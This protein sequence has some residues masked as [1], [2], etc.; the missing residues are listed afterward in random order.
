MKAKEKEPKAQ[1]FLQWVGAMFYPTVDD[2]ID[3]AKTQGIC[4]RI[5]TLPNNLEVGR[6]RIFLAHDE[7]LNGD[8][9]VFGY[10]VPS[11]IE[12]LTHNEKDIPD[13]LQDRVEW[14]S[15]WSGEEYRGCGHREE[16][17]Y[18]SGNPRK[19]QLPG[20]F[21][22]FK[23]PRKLE[24]FDPERGHFRGLLQIDYGSKIVRPLKSQTMV[25]PSKIDRE[26]R[27]VDN[28]ELYDRM[29]AGPSVSRVAQEIAFET[30]AK[31]SSILYR[32]NQL[33]KA[34]ASD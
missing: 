3:E 33:V 19:V 4:K 5:G 23:Y 32:Y 24:C 6:S 21:V 30:G 2:F 28:N 13:R 20:K 11:K 12:Y 10:Y 16:G 26:L 9:F 18:L 31:K 8:S 34:F 1:D 15:N 27:E 14:V 29:Q 25:P 17:M 22:F 7:G